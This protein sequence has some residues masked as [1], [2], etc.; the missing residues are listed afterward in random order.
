VAKA[1]LLQRCHLTNK[2]SCKL[3]DP[4]LAGKGLPIRGVGATPT[5]MPSH[6]EARLQIVGPAPRGESLAYSWRGATP[7]K[8]PSHKET[9][10]QTVGPAPRGERLAYSWRGRHSHKETISQRNTPT[11]CGT[12]ASRGKARLRAN[13]S[14]LPK[15]N[16]LR[17]E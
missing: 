1:P 13:T 16:A 3:W 7:T 8:M 10:L 15:L 17:G 14:P 9:R 12:C 2:H 4:R 6:K 11:N 5:K